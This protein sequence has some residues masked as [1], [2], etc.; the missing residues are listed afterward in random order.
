MSE[1]RYHLKDECYEEKIVDVSFFL[2]R[3]HG[4]IYLMADNSNGEEQYLL[5]IKDGK[6]YYCGSVDMVGIET[7]KSH[8]DRV[9]ILD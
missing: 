3:E 1:I 7:D 4:I 6:F 5:K 2:K 8:R 9:M